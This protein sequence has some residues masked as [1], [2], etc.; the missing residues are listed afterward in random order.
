[1][2]CSVSSCRIK[3]CAVFPAFWFTLLE[4]QGPTLTSLPSGPHQAQALFHQN[5]P[6]THSS[7]TF[8]EARDGWV[9][10]VTASGH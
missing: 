9:A 7:Q 6:G 10:S 1:M 4:N 2:S 3:A 5:L 8:R